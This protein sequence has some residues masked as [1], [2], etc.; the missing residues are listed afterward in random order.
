[1]AKTGLKV[2]AAAASL[3]TVGGVATLL[4]ERAPETPAPREKAWTP[5][6]AAPEPRHVATELTVPVAPPPS[7]RPAV[8]LRAKEKEAPAAATPKDGSL[9]RD[10]A[11]FGIEGL[12]ARLRETGRT[13]AELAHLLPADERILVDLLRAD[14]F[15]AT[16]AA[17][18]LAEIGAHGA[19][20]ALLDALVADSPLETRQSIALAVGRLATPED[21]PAVR[22]LLERSLRG[23]E[24]GP[25]A[26][27]A[28]DA[29][30]PDAVLECASDVRR[31]PAV[32]GAIYSALFAL[33][34][35]GDPRT[36]RA[37]GAALADP[38]SEVRLGALEALTA[39]ASGGTVADRPKLAE[40]L[41]SV[42]GADSDPEV[43]QACAG[44]LAALADPTT[45]G[46]LQLALERENDPAVRIVIEASLDAVSMR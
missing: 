37:L 44:A 35:A 9:E 33:P 28:V 18:R 20:G 1:M 36:T 30:G 45:K 22:A 10:L 40:T 42:L 12:A 39:L 41:V 13:R 14:P 17:E 19:L 16:L 6:V 11:R 32:R 46:S 7:S 4:G 2:I 3:L 15:L 29:L 43:R 34:D 31:D 21:R 8:A 24:A 38:A 26:V 5:S 25:I 27:A 23:D